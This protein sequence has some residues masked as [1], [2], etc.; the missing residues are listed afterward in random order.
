MVVGIDHI[1]SIHRR[2]PYGGFLEELKSMY[3]NDISTHKIS[4]SIGLLLNSTKLN[5]RREGDAET[6]DG[7]KRCRFCNQKIKQKAAFHLILNCSAVR[8]E[9]AMKWLRVKDFRKNLKVLEEL[10]LRANTH[11]DVLQTG[12]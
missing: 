4:Q 5:F 9:S 7:C 8:H 3:S 12:G 6:D 10:Q 11:E 1:L 2:Y